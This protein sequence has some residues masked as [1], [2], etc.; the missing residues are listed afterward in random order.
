MDY[1]YDYDDEYS[2][3]TIATKRALKAV[4]KEYKKAVID[5][6]KPYPPFEGENMSIFAT[7]IWADLKKEFRKP[8]DILLDNFEKAVRKFSKT[9]S[10]MSIKDGFKAYRSLIKITRTLILGEDSSLVEEGEYV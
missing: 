2:E 6:I 1:T 4:S 10:G 3:D 5:L 9:L 7:K 8:D